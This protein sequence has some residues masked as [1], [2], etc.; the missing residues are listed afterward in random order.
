MGPGQV[1]NVTA[2]DLGGARVAIS[3]GGNND[4]KSGKV[5]AGLFKADQEYTLTA[6]V[7]KDG[8]V[9]KVDGEE[10]SRYEDAR[11]NLWSNSWLNSKVPTQ[12]AISADDPA[13]ITKVEVT[14]VSGKGKLLREK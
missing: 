3:I 5:K 14:E 9:V 4:S 1:F 7:R 12:L 13:V 8:I 11:E 6:E 2:A 10:V